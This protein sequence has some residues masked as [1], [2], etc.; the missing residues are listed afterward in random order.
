[1][2]VSQITIL[3]IIAASST[4]TILQQAQ[5]DKND[6]PKAACEEGYF[7]AYSNPGDPKDETTY[8]QL[9]TCGYKLTCMDYVGCQTCASSGIKMY[10][11]FK[12]PKRTYSYCLDC[13]NIGCYGSCSDYKGCT[14]CY[15][16][17]H[18]VTSNSLANGN[19]TTCEQ[20]ADYGWMKFCVISGLIIIAIVVISILQC[21]KRKRMINEIQK[22]QNEYQNYQPNQ[23]YQ[24]PGQVYQEIP[25]QNE[26]AKMQSGPNPFI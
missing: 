12:Y 21:K 22:R 23:V 20:D 26:P 5:A 1:M 13:G 18:L 10:K 15:T 9:C 25:G 17:N 4:Q 3:L 14:S 6:T 2:K 19:L 7:L 16:K 8:C 24:Q 11:N